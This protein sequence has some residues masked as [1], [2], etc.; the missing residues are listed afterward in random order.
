MLIY[1]LEAKED[2]KRLYEKGGE[3]WEYVV[4]LSPIDEF[5]QIFCEWCKYS[6]RR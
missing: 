4:C 2:N 6:E 5:T 3:R 1:I